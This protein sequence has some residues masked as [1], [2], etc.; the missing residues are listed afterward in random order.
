MIERPGTW[1]EVEVGVTLLSPTGQPLLCTRFEQGWYLLE[2]RNHHK[3]R[4][5][6]KPADAAVTVLEVTPEEAERNLVE[7]LGAHRLL[8]LETEKRVEQRQH[9]WEVP[10][11]PVKGQRDALTRARDHVDWYHGTYSGDAIGGGFKT[12]A[13][14]T[15]AHE[16]M[17]TPGNVFTD[18]PHVHKE[19]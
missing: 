6:P 3:V 17:H 2:D 11:F 16:E 4:V 19:I 8:D 5:A 18:K 9:Q 12:L 13:E 10:S 1:S 14:I 15:A 7:L